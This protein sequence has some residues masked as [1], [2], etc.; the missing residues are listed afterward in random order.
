MPNIAGLFHLNLYFYDAF[1]ILKDTIGYSQELLL[2]Y[3]SKI[4]E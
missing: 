4:L 2:Q 3:L 1:L